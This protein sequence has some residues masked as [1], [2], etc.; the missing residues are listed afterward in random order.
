M[1]IPDSMLQGAVCPASAGLGLLGMAVAAAVAIKSDEKPD[2]VRFAGVATLI[3]AAQMVNYPIIGGVSGHLLGAVLAA[4]L[5]GPAFAV[6]AMGLVLAVQALLFADGGLLA[7][8][9]NLLNMALPAVAIGAPL[10]ALLKRT[11]RPALQQALLVVV[12]GWLATMMAALTA[13]IQVAAGGSVSFLEVSGVLLGHHAWI[14]LGEGLMSAV[15]YLALA[16]QPE[17]SPH[18]ERSLALAAVALLLAPWAASVPDA[19]EATSVR[20]GLPFTNSLHFAPLADYAVPALS[21]GQLSTLVAGASGA[22]LTFALA[23]IMASP[24]Q[25]P[26]ASGRR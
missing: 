11:T 20:F 6:L 5:L 21:Q 23:R 1:H 7:L 8:G 15:L 10:H 12:G 17:G 9:A 18:R 14:G 22:L 24:L 16:R 3:F 19:L 13:S 25:R 2:P 26:I 4:I